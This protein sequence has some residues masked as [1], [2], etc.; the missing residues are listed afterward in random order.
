MRAEEGVTVSDHQGGR[1]PEG[2]HAPDHYE[3]AP[4]PPPPGV[5]GHHV[6]RPGTV[7]AASVL[8]MVLGGWLVLAYG[9]AAILAFGAAR[10][11][12]GV[13]AVGLTVVAIVVYRLG[14]RLR[15]GRDTRTALAILGLLNSLSLLPLLLVI[16]AIVLQNRPSARHWL[17][18]P[19]AGSDA[20]HHAG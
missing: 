11:L 2:E 13:M 12:M 4:M 14:R 5:T 17:A 19:P 7:T 15:Y 8:W 3:P 20:A 10:D 9:Y 18:L 6:P 1:S 16:P